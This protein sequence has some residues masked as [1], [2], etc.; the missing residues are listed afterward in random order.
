[1]LYIHIY[2]IIKN[3]EPGLYD[4]LRHTDVSALSFFCWEKD[5]VILVYE[6]KYSQTHRGMTE[7]DI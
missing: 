5:S 6:F 2:Q 1:M 4:T 3:P 7:K